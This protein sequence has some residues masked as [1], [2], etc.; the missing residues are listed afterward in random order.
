VGLH[1][2]KELALLGDI[3][4]AAEAERI[5]LVNRVVP[6]SEL[7]ALVADWAARLAAGPPIALDM[8]KRM[9]NQG[10][11]SSLEEALEVEAIAQSVN[12]AS[13]DTREAVKAFLEKR[14]PVFRGH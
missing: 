10:L 12:I 14:T 9:L 6:V 7:D 5:G 2:A 13:N 1:R 3:L 8:T 11:N 4:P